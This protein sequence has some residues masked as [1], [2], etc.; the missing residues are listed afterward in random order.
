MKNEETKVDNMKK[1]IDDSM[2]GVAEM[3][4][5]NTGANVKQLGA[6]INSVQSATADKINE[7]DENIKKAKLASN[8][9]AVFA[10]LVGGGLVSYFV[11]NK[12][13]PQGAEVMATGETL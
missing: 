2:K 8:I 6:Y 7:M 10:G 12:M 1:A 3:D 13:H 4:E 5:S 11:Y 9:A